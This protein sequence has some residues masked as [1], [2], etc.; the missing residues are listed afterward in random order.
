VQEVV[1]RPGWG[2]N[3]SMVF[4]ITG[5]TGAKRRAWSFDG[6]APAA[7]TLHIEYEGG[8]CNASRNIVADQWES[9][10]LPC[11]PGVNNQVQQ[12]LA[13]LVASGGYDVTWI[14][15][16]FDEISGTYAKLALDEAMYPGQGYWVYTFNAVTVNFV[17]E[18]NDLAGRTLAYDVVNGAQNFVGNYRNEI[19][20][21]PD[22]VVVNGPTEVNIAGADP[23]NDVPPPVAYECDMNPAG[24]D[25]LVSRKSYWWSGSNYDTFSPLVPGFEGEI[26]I[27]HAIFVKAFKA[28]SQLRLPAGVASP[29]AVEEPAKTTTNRT[30]DASV[31]TEQKSFRPGDNDDG[32]KQ[33]KHTDPWMLR[34]IASSGT[35]RDQ[36]NVLGQLIDSEDGLDINDLEELVPFGTKYLSLTFENSLL[37]S[38]DWGFTSDFR[39]LTKKSEGNWPILVRASPDVEDITL[40]WEGN[41]KAFKNAWIRDEQTGKKHKMKENGTYTFANTGGENRFT[42]I[43]R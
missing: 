23:L 10:A 18:F 42:I 22:V 1:D 24:D 9:I 29:A 13:V 34:L 21:W 37:P 30:F 6:N 16:R 28:G 35:K 40:S 36:G 15:Y 7:A 4:V 8:S 41:F 14:V 5:S 38:A 12:V 19:V 27:A 11:D 20:S 39:A 25:C 43:I 17:G 26:P 33:P 3:N 2:V 32:D 31:E